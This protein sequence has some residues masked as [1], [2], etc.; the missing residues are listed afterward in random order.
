MKFSDRVGAREAE[1][2]ISIRE[3]VPEE[4]GSMLVDMAYECDLTG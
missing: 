2:V 1:P 3:D 4:L